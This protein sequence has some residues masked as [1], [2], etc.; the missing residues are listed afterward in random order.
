V[1]TGTLARSPSEAR[2]IS[3]GGL[4]VNGPP[5]LSEG[6]RTG[7]FV[8]EI[9]RAAASVAQMQGV[10]RLHRSIR[11]AHRHAPLRMTERRRAPT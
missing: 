5:C 6:V 2:L 9:S 11:F 1:G 7:R 10:L 8:A 4:V 3:G